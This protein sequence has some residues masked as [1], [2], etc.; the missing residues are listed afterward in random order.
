MSRNT[1]ANRSD[2]SSFLDNLLAELLG[3]GFIGMVLHVVNTPGA[4]LKIVQ[5][6][7]RG[8]TGEIDEA[9][10][11]QFACALYHVC[12]TYRYEMFTDLG[13]VFNVAWNIARQNPEDCT[14][15]VMLN[16][17]QEG[18]S[19]YSET[20]KNAMT[21]AVIIKTGKLLLVDW[22]ISGEPD[23]ETLY[24]DIHGYFDI[25]MTDEGI[26]LDKTAMRLE[27]QAYLGILPAD[28]LAQIPDDLLQ[29]VRNWKPEQND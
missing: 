23:E 5:D 21:E 25:A 29:R 1:K 19:I 22:M 15:A 12:I 26:V 27:A 2:F 3:G 9:F 4:L 13:G 24:A 16:R 7:F 8:E 6:R 28:K 10:I 18:F 14:P 20:I 17:F 11:T